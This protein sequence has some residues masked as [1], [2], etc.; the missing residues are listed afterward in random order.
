[1]A[2]FEAAKEAVWLHNFL[3]DQQMVPQTQEPM[4]L[5][6]DTSGAVTNSKELR[7]H[8]RREHIE[9]IFHLLREIVHKGDIIV[10]KIETAENLANPFTKALTI[11][12]FERHLE[13]MRL[14]IMSHLL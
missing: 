2:T 8:K 12:V 11:K 9:R 5:Y 14:C 13:G 4:T 3:M 10:N 1:M 7:S 6:C